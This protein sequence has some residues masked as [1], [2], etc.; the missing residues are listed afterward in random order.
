MIPLHP[1]ATPDPATLTWVT[2]AAAP[3]GRGVVRRAPAPLQ[4]LLEDGTL[5]RVEVGDD[6]VRTTLAAGSWRTAGARVRTALS[7]SLDADGWVVREDVAGADTARADDATP[8]GEE[9]EATVE[10]ASDAGLLRAATEVLARDVAPYA[11]THGGSIDVVGVHGGVVEV[12]LRGACSGCPAAAL[13]LHARF[14]VLLRRRW[15]AL[16]AV[17]EVSPRRR[18][19]GCRRSSRA[20]R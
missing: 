1:V 19:R 4:T 10:L 16:V 17:R 12:T 8:V 18:G 5:S 15:P 20:A 2:S 9:R 7:T 3:L 11:A 6:G 13:T 14:E